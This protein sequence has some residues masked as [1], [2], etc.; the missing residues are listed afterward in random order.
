[1]DR[2]KGTVFLA[3]GMGLIVAAIATGLSTRHF[4]AH[5]SRGEGVVTRLNAGGSHPEIE[6]TAASGETISFPQG[7]GIFGYRPGQKVQVLYAPEAPSQTACVDAFGAL[8]FTPLILS[9]LG[10][11]FTIGGASM[12]ASARRSDP[13]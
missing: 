2:L 7:G 10:T 12:V 8:W 13:A 4:V 1:M 6:F 5:A 11:G 3:L 9:F